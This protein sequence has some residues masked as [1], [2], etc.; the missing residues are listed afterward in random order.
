MEQESENLPAGHSGLGLYETWTLYQ[1]VAW[2]AL[3]M[4]SES[5]HDELRML[6]AENK[7]L[8]DWVDRLTDQRDQLQSKVLFLQQAN[9]D[10]AEK[11]QELIER[12]QEA[13]AMQTAL[14]KI[15]GEFGRDVLDLAAI[16]KIAR[17]AGGVD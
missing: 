5:I 9:M 3:A 10:W 16:E 6:E 13:Q 1:K 17:E 4:N 8:H 2:G 11:E 15:V 14:L 7:T 12:A